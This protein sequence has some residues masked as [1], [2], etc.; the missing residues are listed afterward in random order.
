M[1]ELSPGVLCCLVGRGKNNNH[2]KQ[3]RESGKLILDHLSHEYYQLNLKIRKL[4]VRPL[5]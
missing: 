3:G 1:Q 4:N 5:F 2:G